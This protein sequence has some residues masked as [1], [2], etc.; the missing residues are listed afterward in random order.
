MGE[1]VNYNPEMSQWVG[2]GEVVGVRTKFHISI[3]DN[4][5]KTRDYKTSYFSPT[6]W[7]SIQKGNKVESLQELKKLVN[8]QCKIPAGGIGLEAYL[9]NSCTE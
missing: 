9:S 2:D 1:V 8:K 6:F 4:I 5:V 7:R 3:E